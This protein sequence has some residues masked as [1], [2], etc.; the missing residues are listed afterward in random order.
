MKT[1]GNQVVMPLNVAKMIE[2]SDQVFKM[3]EILDGLDYRKLRSTYRRHWRSVAPEIMF[4]IIVFANMKGIFSSRG[5]EEACK[6]DI[7]FMWLLQ[8][9]KAP[10]HTTISRFLENNMSGC[11]EDL[12]FQLVE[13]LAEMGEIDFEAL[14][15]DGTKIEANANRYT[16]VW[17]KSVEKRLKKLNEQAEKELSPI[18]AK[19]GLAEWLGLESTISELKSFAG[20]QRIEFVHGKGRRKTQLQR[21][22]ERLEELLNKGNEYMEMLRI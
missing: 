13:K 16:F 15:V 8:Y 19:Y 2:K 6:T 22:C 20:I 3:A 21:D 17:A 7:R 14:F 5:I 9:H 12:F 4:S 18:R 1:R 11:A 10:D